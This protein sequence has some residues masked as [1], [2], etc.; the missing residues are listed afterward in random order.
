MFKRMGNSTVFRAG[1]DVGPRAGTDIAGRNG[2]LK[3]ASLGSSASLRSIAR[4]AK[5]GAS[6]LYPGKFRYR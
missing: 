2:R 4:G 1:C 5:T 3:A 6:E